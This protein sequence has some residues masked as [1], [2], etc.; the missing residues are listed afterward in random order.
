M[1]KLII[2]LVLLLLPVSLLAQH[3]VT[4]TCNAS[5]IPVVDTQPPVQQPVSLLYTFLRSSTTGGPY[6]AVGTSPSCAYIDKTVAGGTTYYYVVTAAV[7][8]SLGS[9]LPSANSNEAVA[10][11]PGS[12]PATAPPAPTGLT[13]GTVSLKK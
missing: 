3:S 2:S 11:V 12:T 9:S 1:K 5:T 10:V 8:N 6:N 4:L 7:F 13:L